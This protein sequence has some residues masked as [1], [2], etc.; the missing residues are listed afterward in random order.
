MGRMVCWECLVV[1]DDQAR[2]WRAYRVEV[3]GQDPEPILLCYCPSCAA[4]EFGPFEAAED[5]ADSAG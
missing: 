4:R 3:P 1:A 2:G 5:S